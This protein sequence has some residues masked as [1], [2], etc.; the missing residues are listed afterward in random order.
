[1]VDFTRQF[2]RAARLD[3]RFITNYNEQKGVSHDGLLP[4]CLN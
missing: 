1:M 2:I 4:F 3:I